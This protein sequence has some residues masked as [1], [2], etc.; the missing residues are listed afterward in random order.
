[1]P[2]FP[3]LAVLSTECTLIQETV[4]FIGDYTPVFEDPS[5]KM[6]EYQFENP[7]GNLYKG[8]QAPG[9]DLTIFDKRGYE[10]K[11]NEKA[12]DWSDLQALV[13]AL[14]APKTD[15]AKWRADLEAVF[16]T[17]SFLK[18]LAIN[19]TIVNFDT[20]GWVTKTI[21]FTKIWPITVVWY[22]SHGIITSP[23]LHQSMGHKTAPAS[24][25][26]KLAETG[27]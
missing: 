2:A 16:N 10:K 14:N 9:G 22:L 1:M 8:Q 27:R 12:D 24:L 19:T 25:W 23:F 7:N 5:D 18:W 15:P 4:L 13:A 17:D 6:L 26:M 3:R 21:I 11:T 20:Y